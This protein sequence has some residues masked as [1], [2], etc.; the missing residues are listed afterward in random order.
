MTATI[1]DDYGSLEGAI[2][3]AKDALRDADWSTAVDHGVDALITLH[4]R[5]GGVL[6]RD[7]VAVVVQL[8]KKVGLSH[9]SDMREAT[10]PRS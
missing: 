7:Q 3:A 5:Q 6:T 8:V 10:Y 1:A 4:Q 9:D 2:V